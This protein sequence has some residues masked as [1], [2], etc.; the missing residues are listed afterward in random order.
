M[1]QLESAK[2]NGEIYFSNKEMSVFAPH[3]TS[4]HKKLR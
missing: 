4:S 3:Q 1:F 2:E